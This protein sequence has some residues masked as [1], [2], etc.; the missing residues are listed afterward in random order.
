MAVEGFVALFC[1]QQKKLHNTNK[2]DLIKIGSAVSKLFSLETFLLNSCPLFFIGVCTSLLCVCVFVFLGTL[3]ENCS[4][5][6]TFETDL[7]KTPSKNFYLE[8][9]SL[10]SK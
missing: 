1:S 4:S 5:G 6:M 10:R 2:S 3:V 7:E 8:R 9:L